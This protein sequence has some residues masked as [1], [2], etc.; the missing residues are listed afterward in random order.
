MD[1]KN[2]RWESARW[3]AI[4][5]LP[6]VSILLFIVAK[7]GIVPLSQP[8]VDG[9]E[10]Y[11]IAVF[12]IYDISAALPFIA[13]SLALKSDLFAGFAGFFVGDTYHQI[14]WTAHYSYSDATFYVL[15]PI[16]FYFAPKLYRQWT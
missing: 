9:W 10:T 13:L 14:C 16:I 12:V 8:S 6:I 15:V 1:K 11:K 5:V 7:F 3:G 4:K 2:I